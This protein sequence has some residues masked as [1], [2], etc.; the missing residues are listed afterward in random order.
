MSE[1][2]KTRVLVTGASGFLGGNILRAM[3]D[4]PAIECIAACRTSAKL[5]DHFSGEVR[6]GD[7]RDAAY[8][9]T[10]VR[11]IDVICHAGSWASM[12]AH[13]KQEEERFF[14]P[15]RDL[16]ELS[17]KHGV[18]RFV[19]ASTVAI[20]AVTR[21]RQPHDDFSAKKPSGF[22]PHLDYLIEIDDYMQ[23]N[24]KH[25][26]T[27]IT[28]RL[29][30]FVGA[31]NRLGTLPALVP[32]LKTFLVPWLA[33]GKARFPLIADSDLGNA[34]AL[35]ASAENLNDYESFNICGPEF[36]SLKEVISY[37]SSKAG[38]PKPLYS[39]PYAAGYSFGW[40]METLKP[41]LPGSS[42]FLTRSIVRLC[43]DWLCP[44]NYAHTKLGYSPK[45]PWRDAIDEHLAD[46]R[47]E[48]YPWPELSQR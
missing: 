10:L 39:V 18:K 21:D 31:G 24:S 5:P 44:N 45:K 11:D 7:L 29:G 30:H 47:N 19:M 27:M 33:A 4:N 20:G 38:V 26:T 1:Q 22:W 13:K 25:G 9:E 35:A 3:S 41:I 43:E 15:T 46:L 16:L 40:L 48:G 37:I 36:P 6:V 12:W 17:I 42:P 14:E 28:L 23:S 2:R 34:F 8:R 32:R